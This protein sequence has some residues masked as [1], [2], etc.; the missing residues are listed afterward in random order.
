M[1]SQYV[2][3]NIFI[4]FLI[5]DLP[6]QFVLAESFFLQ[7]EQGQQ[8]GFVSILVVNEIIW[9]ME[10]YYHLKRP[11]YLPQLIKLLSLK[12]LR[13]VEM[14]K[15]ELIG[16]LE[17]MQKTAIDFTDLYLWTAAQEHPIFS[18]DR[19]FKKL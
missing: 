16:V 3:T 9:I 7:V 15:D 11:E 17:K 1:I 12:N 18:F 5:A 19:D 4:R 14:K 8:I 13:C 10:H 2:D 6:D